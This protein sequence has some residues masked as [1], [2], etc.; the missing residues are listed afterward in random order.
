[1]DIKS[2]DYCAIIKQN[3]S[4]IFSAS[5]K[6]AASTVAAG[7]MKFYTGNNPGDVPGNLP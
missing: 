5:I 6:S 1:M 4:D 7:L 3:I 2:G